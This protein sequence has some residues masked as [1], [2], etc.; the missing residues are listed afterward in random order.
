MYKIERER[1]R[2]REMRERERERER[3][4]AVAKRDISVIRMKRSSERSQKELV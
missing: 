4:R 3:E 2:E 1:E